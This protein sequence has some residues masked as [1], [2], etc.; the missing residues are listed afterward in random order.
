MLCAVKP[1]AKGGASEPG[2]WD[3]QRSHDAEAGAF[4]CESNSR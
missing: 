4:P 1:W 3:G 2:K